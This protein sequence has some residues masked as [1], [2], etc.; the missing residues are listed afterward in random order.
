MTL[1]APHINGALF[2]DHHDVLWYVPRLEP[3][4]W[5]WRHARTVPV[6]YPMYQTGDLITDLLREANA[7][8]VSLPRLL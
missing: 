2:L 5:D 4:H 1:F 7:G 6:G 3:G 8:L